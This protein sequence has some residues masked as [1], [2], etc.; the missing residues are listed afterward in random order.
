MGAVARGV[1]VFRRRILA[2]HPAGSFST[3]CGRRG[4]VARFERIQGLDPQT[5]S[6]KGSILGG[7]GIRLRLGNLCND[8][9]NKSMMSRTGVG[10][11]LVAFTLSTSALAQQGSPPSSQAGRDNRPPQPPMVVSPEV[12]ADR[13]V[14]FRLLAPQAQSVKLTG[15]DIPGNIPPA[16]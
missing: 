10:A 2:K 13:R 8:W 9:R 16:S 3:L 14:T 4:Q 1:S 7:P 12:Q 5:S 15:T 11:A 6:L